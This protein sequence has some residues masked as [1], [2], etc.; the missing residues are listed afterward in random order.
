M[1]RNVGR[2]TNRNAA[3]PIDQQIGIAC[4]QNG[5]FLFRT[6][7]IVREIDRVFVKIGQQRLCHTGQAALCV[8]HG[9]GRIGVHRAK[10]ALTIDQGNPHRPVLR[11]AG[12]RVVNRAVAMRVIR[13]HHFADNFGRF[14]IRSAGGVAA[15][16]S[17][18]QNAPV[19]RLQTIAHIGQG[20]RHDYTHRIIE[21]AGF[22]LIDDVD[23]G[24]V[25]A[26]RFRSGCRRFN[27]VDIVAQNAFFPVILGKGP[28]LAILR[29][30]LRAR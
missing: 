10:V 11:H 18:V 15:H 20:A 28:S 14:A 19:N 23:F 29:T 25:F 1:R 17:R 4:R 21:V 12:E 2:H 27:R 24:K 7:I 8:T 3:G 5:G 26:A 30:A 22:H 9:S 6:V 13:T 16:L